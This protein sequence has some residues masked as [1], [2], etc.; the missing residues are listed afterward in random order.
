MKKEKEKID[1]LLQR[2]ATEQLDNVDWDKLNTAISTKLDEA[3]SNVLR[4]KRYPVV[5]KIAAGIAVAAAVIFIIVM[6]KTES[7]QP[8]KFEKHGKAV[9]TFIDKKGAA[10]VDIEQVDSQARVIVDFKDSER[11]VAKCDIKISDFDSDLKEDNDQPTWIIISKP[12]PAVAN[13]GNGDEDEMSLICL[14]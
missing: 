14:M 6:V 13:N 8:V 3:E 12:E 1:S 10:V 11:N 7:P 9:V 2:N 5:F 4:A